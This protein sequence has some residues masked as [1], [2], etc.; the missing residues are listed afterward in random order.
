MAHVQLFG[1]P[2]DLGAGRRGVDMGP[3]ALRLARLGPTLVALGHRVDDLGN[4]DVPIAEATTTPDEV[5]ARFVAS[6]ADVTRRLADAVAGAAPGAIPVVLGGDHAVSMGSIAGVVRRARGDRVGVLWID[7]H[8][9][10]NTPQT[11]PSGNVHGMPLAHLLGHG[12]PRLLAAIGAPPLHPRDVAFLG[13]RS[14]D[15][16]ERAF[17]HAHGLTAWTMSDLDRIGM[18]AATGA[19]LEALAHVDH[20]HVSFDADALDPVVAPGVGT[21]VAG[22]LGYREAHLLMELLASSGRVGSV[23]L[24]EV[25]PILDERNAS[26]RVMVELA[27]SLFGRTIL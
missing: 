27:A 3:S 13:L 5:G 18:A 21:P 11:S 25:N 6:I 10:L 12:D 23:D 2:M 1:S 9:D 26:A 14:V 4:V 17:I 19:A 22:G 7:A 24:V 8:A 20:L 16:A 15:P